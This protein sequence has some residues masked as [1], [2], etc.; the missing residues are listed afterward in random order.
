VSRP[1]PRLDS[2]T[3]W[4][5]D[6][7][8]TPKTPLAMSLSNMNRLNDG[9]LQTLSIDRHVPE[10]RRVAARKKIVAAISKR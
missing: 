6:C 2:F 10:P 8:A 1:T 7:A 5:W 4:W 3:A 9:D